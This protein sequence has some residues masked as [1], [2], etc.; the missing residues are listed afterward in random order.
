LGEDLTARKRADHALRER[1]QFIRNLIELTPVVVDV[2][3]LQTERHTYFTSDV[4][5]LFGHSADEVA[6]MP[7]PL[8][9][10]VHPDDIPRVVENMARLKRLG[11]GEI[12]EIEVR[13]HRRDGHWR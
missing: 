6:Q 10:L 2:F 13:V 12:Q 1:N 5:A 8:T 7:D 9:T 4:D 11:D 3:D